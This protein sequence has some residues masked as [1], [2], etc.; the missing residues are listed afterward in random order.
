MLLNLR[1]VRQRGIRGGV[2]AAGRKWREGRRVVGQLEEEA[3]QTR[4]SGVAKNATLR[5][6]RPDPSL[7]KS[8]LLRMTIELTHYL[9]ESFID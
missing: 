7:H 6:A 1:R 4:E 5:A 8:G 3:S 2:E 9:P